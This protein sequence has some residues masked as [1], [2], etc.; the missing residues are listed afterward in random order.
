MKHQYFI[1]I[2]DPITKRTELA[3]G[4]GFSSK[5]KA[6]G[7]ASTINRSYEPR[8]VAQEKT[9]GARGNKGKST[10]RKSLI[11]ALE[12]GQS[13]VFVPPADAHALMGSIASSFTAE[14]WAPYS[15]KVMLLA[16]EG[17][18]ARKVVCV[19]RKMEEPDGQA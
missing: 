11:L 6:E 1:V 3:K 17:E 18:V 14:T 10:S 15:Q 5:A 2:T 12:P 7:Y 9:W 19:T 16:A 4:E 8:V 13:V